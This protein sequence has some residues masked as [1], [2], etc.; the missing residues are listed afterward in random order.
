MTDT[1]VIDIAT[2]ALMVSVKLA[3][4][5][6][7]VSL[8]IGVL[9]SLLQTVTQVQEVTLTFVP[10]LAGVA[11]VILVGGNWMLHEIVHFT[12]DLY[13]SVPQLLGN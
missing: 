7:I 13:M 4:P 2:K 9:V 5:I 3:A 8:A 12:Q 6:L 11:L 1:V 10:K